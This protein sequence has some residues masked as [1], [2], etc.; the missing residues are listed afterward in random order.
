MVVGNDL[1]NEIRDDELA[2]MYPTWGTGD[3][4]T[5]WKLA[6]TKVGNAIL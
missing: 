5:D 4:T 6:A 2:D 3:E 1:Y